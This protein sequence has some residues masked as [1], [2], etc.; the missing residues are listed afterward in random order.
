[1]I[2]INMEMPPKCSRCIL[3]INQKTND[4]GSFGKCSLQN[5]KTVNCLVWSRDSDC[6]LTEIITCKDCKYWDKEKRFCPVIKCNT[7]KEF[8]CERGKE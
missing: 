2:A 7:V 5:E 4:Y 6:P 3:C 8:Y 1:M